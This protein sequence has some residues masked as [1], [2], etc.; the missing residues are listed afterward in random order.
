MKFSDSLFSV[1]ALFLG[2]GLVGTGCRVEVNDDDDDD[3][4]ADD[5]DTSDDDDATADDDTSDDDSVSDDDTWPDDDS[6]SDDDTFVAILQDGYAMFSPSGTWDFWDGS[7][8]YN[9]WIGDDMT[10]DISYTTT[11]DRT[12][13]CDFCEFTF[14]VDYL[15]DYDNSTGDCTYTY[16]PLDGDTYSFGYYNYYGYGFMLYYISYGG[17]AGFYTWG[18]ATVGADDITYYFANY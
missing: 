12:D 4:V 11:G 13:S 9:E 2:L 1:S 10:C 18:Y 17:Y 6:V 3:S 16:A 14:D 7:E 5:D 15:Q 8:T